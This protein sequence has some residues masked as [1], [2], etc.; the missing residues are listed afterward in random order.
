[1]N[2]H[3]MC[4]LVLANRALCK[5]D[6]WDKWFREILSEWGGSVWRIGCGDRSRWWQ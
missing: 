5:I 6:Q 1:L 4:V 2:N 3:G